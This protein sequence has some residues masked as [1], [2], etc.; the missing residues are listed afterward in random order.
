M[1]KPL[2]ILEV[3][4]NH[5]GDLNHLKKIINVYSKITSKYKI[6][7]DFA[8]KFQFR[9]LESYIH[10]TANK[11]NKGVIRFTSTRFNQSEWKKV[12]RF[13]KKKFKIICTPFDEKSIINIEKNRFDFLKIASCS[14]DDWPLIEKIKKSKLPVICSIGGAEENQIT[15]LVSFFKKKIESNKFYLMYCVALYPTKI[16][17]LNLEYFSKLK[18][19]FGDI[20]Q[21]FSSHE[22]K[23]SCLTGAIAYSKGARIFE[24][25]INLYNNKYKINEYSTEP[26]Q[27]DNWLSS[28]AIAIK[29]NGNNIDRNKN[30]IKEKKQLIKFQRGV[31]VSKSQK[32]LKG[33]ELKE[34][35]VSFYFP[36]LKNQLT[37]NK[38]SKYS[39][40]LLKKDKNSLEPIFLDEVKILDHRSQIEIIKS[41]IIELIKL[42][43]VTLPK[44]IKLEISHHYGLKNFNKFGLSMITIVNEKYCKKLLFLINNQSHPKQYHK[45]KHESFFLLYG[46]IKVELNSKSFILKPGDIINIPAQ[47]KHFF[48]DISENGSVIEELS[49]TSK[50][51]DSFYIDK[52]INKNIKRKSFVSINL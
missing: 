32:L 41:K 45:K 7:I 48:K 8:I 15:K 9:D 25:H 38:F 44:N 24:R 36:T 49:T 16:N 46:K 40:F 22:D 33:E 50:K 30:L 27:F 10:P 42:S 39:T 12:V 14:Y 19:K 28:L 29:I 1:K 21:G 20:V 13:A 43:K 5:M 11:H 6:K 35:N 3:A 52:K 37:A 31:Y 2:V 4:N 51:N 23:S 47:V 34:K 26:K 17:D 18:N